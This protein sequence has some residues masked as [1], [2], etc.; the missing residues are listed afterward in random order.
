MVQCLGRGCQVGAD[1]T[2]AAGV[3]AARVRGAAGRP[4]PAG[5]A[6]AGVRVPRVDVRALP[7][8][9]ATARGRHAVVPFGARDGA[10]VVPA[11]H[12]AGPD[13]LIPG[14]NVAVVAHERALAALHVVVFHTPVPEHQCKGVGVRR[15]F[16][17]QSP[18]QR[19]DQGAAVVAERAEEEVVPLLP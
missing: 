3:A 2:D 12:R 4:K 16:A 6:G 17:H 13:R 8:G 9:R 5:M 10:A 18:V 1:L 15:V 11:R 19:C 7:V 14:A